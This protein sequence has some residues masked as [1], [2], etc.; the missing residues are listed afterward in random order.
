MTVHTTG[1]V[2]EVPTET[3]QPTGLR[4]RPRRLRATALRDLVRETRITPA[5]LIHPLFVTAG[6]G[7]E[8]EISPMPGQFQR[9][10][11]LLDTEIQALDSRGVGAVLLFG[12]PET[13][14]AEGTG[15]WDP[16][17]PVPRA[18]AEIRR[19]A[20]GMAVIAD[21]CLCEY[22][23]HG[24]CGIL[25]AACADVVNDATLPLLA[26]AAVAYA[27]AGVDIVAPSA[28]MDG[29][30]AAI[31]DA[32]DAAG[33]A[34]V[35]IMSYSAKYASGFYGPFRV[36]ADSAPAE[37]D[38]RT[39]QMDPA[40]AREALREVALDLAEGADVVMV[41]PAG[42][43][44]DIIRQV[45]DRVEVPV[46]AYQVSGEYAMLKAAAERGWLDERRV[47]MESLTAIRRAGADLIITYYARQAAEW[48]AHGE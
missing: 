43:Y 24:H 30:V 13:K 22:T 21:V 23:D 48:L 3:A 41:K 32:L 20:P 18:I 34:A 35:A 26:R 27:D 39:H 4:H 10:V 45:R 37:G 36:A 42:A 46:A 17:G 2:A 19:R 16:H 38:R 8:R 12:L 11:D 1:E 14:D 9:S 15:A 7:V 33:H 29:Q 6:S 28:M 31:R 25:D 44:L 5:Q 40:N 47:A